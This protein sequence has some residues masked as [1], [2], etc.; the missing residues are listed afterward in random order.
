[1]LDTL[2]F[3]GF[4]VL[5]AFPAVRA[6]TVLLR[7]LADFL[8][9]LPVFLAFLALVYRLLRYHLRLRMTVMLGCEEASGP[10]GVHGP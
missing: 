8:V 4:Q 3:Q 1:M 9:E 5:L 6:L 10:E 2:A 7:F